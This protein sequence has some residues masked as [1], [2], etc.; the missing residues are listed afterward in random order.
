MS[1]LTQQ[2]EQMTHQTMEAAINSGTTLIGF[3]LS[4]SMGKMSNTDKM[5]A[6]VMYNMDNAICDPG[7]ILA[8]A[9]VKKPRQ[10]FYSTPSA[11]TESG[12]GLWIKNVVG[13][14]TILDEPLWFEFRGIWENFFIVKHRADAETSQ[15]THDRAEKTAHYVFA[16]TVHPLG[17]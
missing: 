13:D 9:S 11:K 15:F 7:Q 16:I 5:E 10:E 3:P 17:M 1:W 8:N 12:N 2:L 6:A 4:S 14:N